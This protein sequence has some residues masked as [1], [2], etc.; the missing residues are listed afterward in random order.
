MAVYNTSRH[1][2]GGFQ[3]NYTAF[4]S[5]YHQVDERNAL[6]YWKASGMNFSLDSSHNTTGLSSLLFPLYGIEK[7]WE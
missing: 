1:C 7:K 2:L 6:L 4:T 5:N 3:L